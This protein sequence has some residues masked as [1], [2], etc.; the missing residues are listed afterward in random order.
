LTVTCV[1]R[2]FSVS[3]IRLSQCGQILCC[4]TVFRQAVS[5][6]ASHTS[7]LATVGRIFFTTLMRYSLLT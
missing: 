1:A 3:A 5:S 6:P 4:A 7:V 2:I